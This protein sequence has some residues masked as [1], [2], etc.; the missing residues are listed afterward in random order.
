MSTQVGRSRHQGDINSTQDE[1]QKGLIDHPNGEASIFG[2]QRLGGVAF[3]SE[4]KA[5]VLL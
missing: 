4:G 2:K 1:L 3:G 5:Q